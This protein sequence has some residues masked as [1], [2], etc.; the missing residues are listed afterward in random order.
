MG[1]GRLD[2]GGFGGCGSHGAGPNGGGPYN[3]TV[4]RGDILAKLEA[5]NP[6]GSVKD[7]T[8]LYMIKDAELHG[9]LK[10]GGTIIE[11]TSGNTGVGLAMIAAVRGYRLVL[12]MPDSMSM[13]R[14]KLLAA[15]GAEIV[16]TPG[17][18]GMAG[19]VEAACS[20][21]KEHSDWF[22]PSQFENPSN[23]RAHEETTAAEIMADLGG[24]LDAFVAGI[25]TGG[26]I[27]GVGRALRRAIPGVR[28]VGVEPAESAVLSGG[29]AG[30]H[31][32]QGIGA[33]FV[34][35]VLDMSVVDEIIA[36][37]S[38]DALAAARELAQSEGILVGVSS[39]AAAVAALQVARRLGPGTRVLALFPDTGERY[40][41]VQ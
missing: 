19:S 4:V 38:E 32:I 16:L 17:A 13:E 24:A 2:A 7:R 26:T 41:S 12:T 25:G 20:L 21:Q 22:M 23:P 10:P 31:G 18:L 8:A 6:G 15:Y 27:T 14:R 39:G 3:G 34:P 9:L 29:V 1:S 36:V 35:R 37:G 28:I 11:P 33:G 30:P 5:K 40:L